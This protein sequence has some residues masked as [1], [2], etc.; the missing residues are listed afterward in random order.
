MK[1]SYT[2]PIAIVLGGIVVAFAVYASLPKDPDSTAG[3][4]ALVRPVS[5][6]DHIFGNPAAR[7]KIVTYTDFNCEYC[8]EFD[9]TM[10]HIIANEGTKGEVA[11]VYREFPLTEIHPDAPRHAE[12]AECI[13]Q[14]AGNDA[15]WKFAKVL[16]ENQPANPS[17]YGTYAKTSDISSDT[18][19]S[20]FA[21]TP[22]AISAR[23]KADR[24]NALT[25]GANGTPYSV[26]IVGGKPSIVMPGAYPYGAVKELIDEALAN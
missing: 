1:S 17:A 11:W 2:I 16:F 6:D 18:F 15:F 24:E 26:L 7:V 4:P 3:N 13:A 12:A 20:C 23:I 14:T 25:V 5:A 10:R 8:K 22:P 19:A 21:D 9:D